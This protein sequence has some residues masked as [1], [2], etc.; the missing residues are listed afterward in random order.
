MAKISKEEIAELVG[1]EYYIEEATWNGDG[2]NDEGGYFTEEGVVRFA[3][4]FM[5]VLDTYEE[6]DEDI[7]EDCIINI[8]DEDE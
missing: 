8:V 7:L 6:I 5:E 1:K 4:T 2:W 3:G